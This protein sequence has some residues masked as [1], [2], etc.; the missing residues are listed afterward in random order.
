MTRLDF[1]FETTPFFFLRHG[2]TDDHREQ[3]VM[4][5]L[6]KPLNDR[7][8]GQAHGAA[9]I[10]ADL[11]IRSIFAS[12]LQRALVTAQIIGEVIGVRIQSLPGLMERNYGL[13][14]GLERFKRVARILPK[15]DGVECW[16]AF[17]HRTR[18]TLVSIQ[19]Q[20]PILVV[21]HNGTYKAVIGDQNASAVNARPLQLIPPKTGCDN[22]ATRTM[23]G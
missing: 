1:D 16:Q 19:G 8:I 2:E 14:Q 11:G 5:Q 7:G 12:P 10:I 3:R 15:P 6:D 23:G 4:G 13:Y 21:G 18:S 17:S 20:S 9:Q 22:W